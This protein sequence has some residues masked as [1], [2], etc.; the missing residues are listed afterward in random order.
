[1]SSSIGCGDC[2][3]GSTKSRRQYVTGADRIIA[4]TCTA[5]TAASM[6]GPAGEEPREYAHALREANSRAG[7]A[8]SRAGQANSRALC[9]SDHSRGV[10]DGV[11]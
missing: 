10:N 7:E 1:M 2:S 8:N 5:S 3:P 4:V 9:L 6:R 11:S